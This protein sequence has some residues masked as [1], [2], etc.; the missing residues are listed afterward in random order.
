MHETPGKSQENFTEALRAPDSRTDAP[1]QAPRPAG[2]GF[3]E[4]DL[5]LIDALQSAPRAP[6]ARIGR[7]LGID[8]TTA[9]RRWERLRA[10][11]LAWV[12]AY[13]SARATYVGFAEVRCRPGCLAEVSAAVSALP[14][15][16]SVSETAGDYDL[17]LNVAASDPADIGRAVDRRVGRLPGVHSLRLRLGVTLYGEGGDWRIR[18]MEPAGRAELPPSATT[19]R[20]AYGVGDGRRGATPEDLALLDALSADGRL[21]YTALGAA[22]GVSEHT[23]RRRVRRMLKDGDITLRCDFAHPLAG[24]PTMAVYRAHAP[25]SRLDATGGALARMEQV[26]LCGSI[27]GPDNLHIQVLLHGLAGMDPFQAQLAARF[28]DLE[29]RDRTVTLRAVKRMGWL[30]DEQGRAVDRVPLA[31]PSRP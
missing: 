24:L 28:P 15:V 8:A 5:A 10:A 21:G 2:L 23:A 7:A 12:T 19:T 30:L 20:T 6:W 17:L 27:S 18:A 3:G 26:R 9:A 25:Y 29:I 31:P 1:P 14:W 4:E 13:D 11:G 22:A 16:F